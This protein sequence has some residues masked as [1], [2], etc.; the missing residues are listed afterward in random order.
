MEPADAATTFS[1]FV[2]LLFF[3][4]AVHKL[5]L[6]LTASA[7]LH[8]L[9]RV[10]RRLRAHAAGV[11]FT[12]AGLEAATVGLLMLALVPGLVLAATMALGYALALYVLRPEA[13]CDCFGGL[14]EVESA[15]IAIARNVVIAALA[16]GLAAIYVAGV[17]TP[18]APT[19]TAFAATLVLLAA[20]AGWEAAKNWRSRSGANSTVRRTTT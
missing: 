19:E 14:L 5:R 3:A 1:L 16:S 10:R 7:G 2:A 12:T 13:G 20:I 8:P 15:N 17:L 18:K 9:L 4:A 11:L 6:L